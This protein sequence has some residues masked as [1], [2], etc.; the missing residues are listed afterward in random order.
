M[1]LSELEWKF[2]RKEEMGWSPEPESLTR[3]WETT[4]LEKR[5]C[6]NQQQKCDTRRELGQHSYTAPH[7]T[8]IMPYDKSIIYFLC[9]DLR[10]ML[11]ASIHS[12]I[13][14]YI[15]RSALGG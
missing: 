15:I 11:R 10:W 9:P 2:I 3:Y 6:T 4:W 8:E 14:S 12:T 13:P 5:C 7:Q 1:I